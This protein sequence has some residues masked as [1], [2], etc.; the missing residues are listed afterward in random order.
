MGLELEFFGSIHRYAVPLIRRLDGE[1]HAIVEFTKIGFRQHY[2]RANGRPDE[3]TF[4]GDCYVDG[5]MHGEAGTVHR[6]QEGER[7]FNVRQ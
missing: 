6:E 5:I 7:V 3:Y 2:H 4:I 1:L